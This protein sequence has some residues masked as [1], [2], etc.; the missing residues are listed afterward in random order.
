[1]SH[2]P[3]HPGGIN[4]RMISRL[5]LSEPLDGDGQKQMEAF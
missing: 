5:S 4:T 2:S 1:M 3:R